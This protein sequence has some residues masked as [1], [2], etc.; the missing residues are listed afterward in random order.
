[1]RIE[2]TRG[3]STYFRDIN[4]IYNIPTMKAALQ[5]SQLSRTATILCDNANEFAPLFEREHLKRLSL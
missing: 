4:A 5:L 2:A 3:S 1:M